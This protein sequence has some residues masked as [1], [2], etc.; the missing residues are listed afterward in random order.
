MRFIRQ[1]IHYLNPLAHFGQPPESPLVP[2]TISLIFAALSEF[3]AK[4]LFQNP[5]IVGSFVIYL[6][7]AL[8]T[9][10][11]FRFGTLGGV[12][13]ALSTIAYYFY[14]IIDRQTP[15]TRIP[16]AVQ[17]TL[18]LGFTQII[19][20]ITI[21]SLKCTIN[22]FIEREA[23]EN[24]RLQA[25]LSQLPVGVMITDA[26]GTIER[27][28]KKLNS[29]FGSSRLQG[30]SL[31]LVSTTSSDSLMQLAKIWQALTSQ[32][33]LNNYDLVIN[34]ASDTSKHLRINASTIKNKNKVI[35]TATIISDITQEKILEARKDDF[36][37][38]AS[39]ELKTP[40][41]SLKLYL[42][43]LEKQITSTHPKA[44]TSIKGIRHQINRLQQIINDLLD[45]SRLQTGKLSYR[46]E[47]FSFTQLV[48]ETVQSFQETHP[49]R[50]FH[51]SQSK[52]YQVHAD[53]FRLYQV[54]SNLFS[55]AIKY[56]PPDSDIHIDLQSQQE[57]IIFSI[58]DQGIGIDHG[59]QQ[60]I[61]DR[62][63]QVH[64][65]IEQTFPGF[66]MGLYI[67]KKIIKRHQGDIWVDS[68]KGSGSTFYIRLPLTTSQ[69]D[70]PT[71][72]VLATA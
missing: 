62:L 65:S 43:F 17:M 35:A 61:F 9:Y 60:A 20:A 57:E 72:P 30:Q 45:A 18:G 24:K 29:M 28:N 51:F 50:S 52:D 10:N 12:L 7:F 54:L 63:Y 53:P 22:Q 2:L 32:T 21:G 13:T 36:V 48:Q 47:T 23:N 31:K 56:S 41:T 26:H 38:I 34:S 44:N 14:I 39:H 37:N 49:N 19:I 70:L 67:S 15:A 42:S 3:I 71:K 11:A 40:V 1:I 6:F 55:N 66:G 58:T 27:T 69:A 16:G 5:D 4:G 64:D 25:I 46:F 59:H 33:S 8:T 68:Q